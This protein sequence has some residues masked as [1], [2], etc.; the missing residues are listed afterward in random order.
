[1]RNPIFRKHR[2]AH[3]EGTTFMKGKYGLAAIAGRENY[4]CIFSQNVACLTKKTT[5]PG[6]ATAFRLLK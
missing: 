6:L 5:S 3:R 4:S 1:M 2:H